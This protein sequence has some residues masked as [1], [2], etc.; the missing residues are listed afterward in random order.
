MAHPGL[1]TAASV[2]YRL[3]EPTAVAPWAAA[4]APTLAQRVG[5]DHLGKL[6]TRLL[7]SSRAPSTYNNYGGKL[8][9]FLKYCGRQAL[10]PLQVTSEDVVRYVAWL[11]E[12]GTISAYSMQ[13]YLSAINLFLGDFGL[14]GVAKG[15]LVSKAVEG[16]KASQSL[17]SP[18]L[19]TRH[20][21][22]APAMYSILRAAEQLLSLPHSLATLSLAR[23][24][25]ATVV[26]YIFF[27]RPGVG[28][29]VSTSALVVAHPEQP[30][31]CQ[32]VFT[33]VGAKGK[34]RVPLGRLA[35]LCIPARAHAAPEHAQVPGVNIA[36]LL[37]TFIQ[38]RQQEFGS[39][40][41][42]S[43]F[44]ALP[45]ERHTSWTSATQDGWL[46]EALLHVGLEPPPGQAWS[47]H[48]PRKGA[49]S[50]AN[51]IGVTIAKIAYY[52][53]WAP[54]STTLPRDYIDP[55][56]PATPAALFF[57]GWLLAPASL[58]GMSSSS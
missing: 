48:S 47:G 20:P 2:K 57:F 31:L 39:E 24:C 41:P 52:G 51:A 43:A 6:A 3:G 42:P 36:K 40:A 19:P 53:G 10:D 44:W 12:R 16:L 1:T 33:P 34:S 32:L 23:A 8:E 46:Q 49:A 37:L 14:E 58:S 18:A 55:T 25:L 27:S 56:M 28:A 11:G 4:L 22:P 35:P 5:D 13:P 30:D 38:R 54:S 45:G 7:L 26:T 29:K 9:K 50:A 17:V 21:I 15:P